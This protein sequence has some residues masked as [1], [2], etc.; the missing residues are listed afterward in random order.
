ILGLPDVIM[1]LYVHPVDQVLKLDVLRGV[2]P[3]SFY[4]SVKVYHESIDD[5]ADIPGLQKS[6]VRRLNIFV[7]DLDGDIRPLL[8][9]TRSDSG[10][11]VVAQISGSNAMDSGLQTG[12]IIRAV[13]RTVLQTSAQ[14]ETLVHNLS[15]GDPVVLQVERKGKL[16]YLAFEM[17]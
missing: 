11:L 5:L 15:S 8:Q 16:Q 2:T 3:M 14:F 10:V 9:D 13:D 7:T 12:D 17:D 1:A 6:L 4:V